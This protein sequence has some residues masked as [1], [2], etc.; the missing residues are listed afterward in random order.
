MLASELG[1]HAIH[2]AD[3]ARVQA[4]GFRPDPQ[5]PLLVETQMQLEEYFASRRKVFKLPL[6]PSGTPFQMQIW[7][8]L[9]DIPFGKTASYGELAALAGDANAS[10]AVGMANNRNPI[11]IIIPCHRVIGS[12]GALTGFGGGLLNKSIL[13]DLESQH[14]LF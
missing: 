6:A 9:Q 14:R 4:E 5:Y 8:L 2:W 3:E 7:K 1:L 12:S 11:P 10:R 13:L